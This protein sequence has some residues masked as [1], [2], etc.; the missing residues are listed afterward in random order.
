MRHLREPF[1][2]RALV[3]EREKEIGDIFDAAYPLFTLSS[4]LCLCRPVLFSRRNTRLSR[5]IARL[6]SFFGHRRCGNNNRRR[7]H[8]IR[9]LVILQIATSNAKQLRPFQFLYSSFHSRGA[10]V[11]RK[12]ALRPW[13]PCRL[14]PNFSHVSGDAG[15]LNPKI[16]I[17]IAFS[18]MWNDELEILRLIM[19]NHER[20]VIYYVKFQLFRFLTRDFLNI[21]FF[22]II[23]T[24]R[25]ES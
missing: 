18:K 3:K 19:F 21:S 5:H 25:K 1:V 23:I 8:V 13:R 2:G 20:M 16:F 15:V 6:R 22:F 17:R 7:S 12:T 14:P 11:R 10:R 24:C 9:N 4:S